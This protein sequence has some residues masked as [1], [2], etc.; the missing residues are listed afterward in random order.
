MLELGDQVVQQH[1]EAG[2]EQF[3]PASLEELEQLVLVLDQLVQAAVLNR[4][5]FRG[6]LLA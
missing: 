4:T 2:V 6:G 1:L 5:G 3:T